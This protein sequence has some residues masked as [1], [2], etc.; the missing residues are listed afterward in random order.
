VRLH[1]A[2]LRTFYRFLVER[3][4]LKDNPLKEVQLPKL[5]KKLPLSH[6][7]M[8]V[9]GRGGFEIVQKALAAG[10]PI[11]ASVSAPSSLVARHVAKAYLLP[12]LG[13]V[14]GKL[15]EPASPLQVGPTVADIADGE[16]ASIQ[17]GGDARGSHPSQLRIS[18]LA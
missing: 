14:L 10:I 9:S 7:I 11:L 12:Y 3:H 5:E 6:H 13:M 15:A 1:F 2:A 4:G 8:L 16:A 17:D 18:Y